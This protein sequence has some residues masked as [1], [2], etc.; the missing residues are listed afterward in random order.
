MTAKDFGPIESDYEFFMA[1]ATEAANDVAE[2]ARELAGFARD[3]AAIRLL[4]YGC[5]NGEFS[6]RFLSTMRWPPHQLQLTLV[7][8]VA[9]QR[10]Q[11]AQRLAQFSGQSLTSGER[12]EATPG[13]PFDLIVSNHALYYVDDLH[14][15]LQA[16][17]DALAPDGRLLL[18]IAGF[19]NMLCGLWK[20]GF[21]LLGKPVPYHTAEDVEAE[22]QR[23]S[24]AFRRTESPYLLRFP[25]TDENRQK[26]LRFL[27]GDY[28]AAIGPQHML[29]EFDRYV[30]EGHVEIHTHSYHYAVDRRARPHT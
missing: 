3:R 9:H 1:H 7:E 30:F 27:F 25:D 22:L 18:A 5:G 2:Y 13:G 10:A 23:D 6:Q 29:E 16:L 12:L 20:I 19:D 24:L 21:A 11:A 26:I 4:D 14:A 15:T 8:P 17:V 28:L